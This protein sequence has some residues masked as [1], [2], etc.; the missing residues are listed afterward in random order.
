MK[1]AKWMAGLAALAMLPGCMTEREYAAY[2]T[3]FEGSPKL[4]QEAIKRCIAR[5]KGKDMKLL[6]MLAN[7]TPEK[8]PVVICTRIMNAVVDGK[9]TY[10]DYLSIMRYETPSPKQIKI[11]QGRL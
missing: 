11:I 7:T 1:I 2:Q 10:D 4:R 8:T 9:L 6:S 3:A 5:G